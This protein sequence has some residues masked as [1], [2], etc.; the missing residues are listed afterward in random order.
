MIFSIAGLRAARCH[1]DDLQWEGRAQTLKR[2][3]YPDRERQ[4]RTSRHWANR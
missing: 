2:V 4:P 3:G 1:L